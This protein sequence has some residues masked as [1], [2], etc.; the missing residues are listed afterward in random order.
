MVTRTACF[1]EPLPLIG[2]VPSGFTQLIDLAQELFDALSHLLPLR[3]QSAHLFGQAGGFAAGRRSL[4]QGSLLLRPQARYQLHGLLNTLLQAAERI[5]FLLLH[6]AH[7][8]ASA[9]SRPALA[10]STN[11]RNAAS[12]L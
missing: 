6:R 5:G 1:S 2:A 3:L 10:A 9:F 11:C 12:S 4:F 8:C 7:A